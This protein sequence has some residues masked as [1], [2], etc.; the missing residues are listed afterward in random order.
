MLNNK[1]QALVIF[2][3]IMPVLLLFL[4]YVVDTVNINYE[5]NRLENIITTIKEDESVEK[6]KEIINKN[7]PDVQI[8][9]VDNELKVTK[10]VK[11]FFGKIIGRY[12]YEIVEK[13]KVS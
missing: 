13:V 7:E 5:K 6:A 10:K 8:E 2:V 12:Y 9:I 1:A 3:I 4:A 11:C